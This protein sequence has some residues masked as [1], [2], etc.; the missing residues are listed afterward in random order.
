MVLM[1]YIAALKKTCE[2]P[3]PRRSVRLS[4]GAQAQREFGEGA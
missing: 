4:S 2:S 1:G 3:R